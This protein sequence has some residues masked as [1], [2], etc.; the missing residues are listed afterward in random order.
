M[1]KR[2]RSM[3]K[4]NLPPRKR[5]MYRKSRGRNVRTGGFLGMESKFLDCAWNGVSISTSTDGSGGELQ[6]SSGCTSAISVPSQGDGESQRD[7]RKY[8][9]T[10]AWVSGIV[11]TSAVSD[12]ADVLDNVGYYFALVLDTQANGATVNSEDVYLNPATVASAMLPQPLRNLQN[13]KRFRILATQYVAPGGTYAF[14][15][16]AATGSVSPME[17]PKVNLSW[18]GKVFCECSGTTANISSATDNALHVV[19]YA[20]QGSFSPTFVGKSRIRFQG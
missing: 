10:S 15:D 9:I 17:A 18:N 11:S 4:A 16:A 5:P 14:N 3:S 12:Q 2:K 8:C 6:P 13:S 20:G 19:A 1:P 7:G